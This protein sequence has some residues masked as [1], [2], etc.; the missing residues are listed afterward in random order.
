MQ[1]RAGAH[2]CCLLIIC[3]INKRLL[4]PGFFKA[5]VCERASVQQEA[6]LRQAQACS[7]PSSST[8]RALGQLSLEDQR[9]QGAQAH[10][11]WK[12]EATQMFIPRGKSKLET[13]RALQTE[14]MIQL[15]FCHCD[16]DTMTQQFEEEKFYFAY[17]FNRRP[18]SREAKVGTR[19]RNLKTGTTAETMEG[20]CS[21][22][23]LCQLGPHAQEWMALPTMSWALPHQLLSRRCPTNLPIGNFLGA[24]SSFFPQTFLACITLTKI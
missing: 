12:M 3:Q 9:P 11:L 17:T 5:G 1:S 22:A 18:L 13:P 15:A 4:E 21:L 20:H 23:F 8:G 6:G 2:L 24:F 7:R 10:T 19:G 14:G 16:K